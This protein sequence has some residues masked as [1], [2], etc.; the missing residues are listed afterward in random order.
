MARAA[1]PARAATR[2]RSAS[3]NVALAQLVRDGNGAQPFPVGHQRRED[4]I[5]APRQ[6]I[7]GQEFQHLGL[8]SEVV[9]LEGAGRGPDIGRQE[10]RPTGMLRP[11]CPSVWRP[12]GMR[13]GQLGV[14]F[15]QEPERSRLALSGGLHLP[16]DGDEQRVEV[17]CGVKRLPQLQEQRQGVGTSAGSDISLLA[18]QDVHKRPDYIERTPP[19]RESRPFHLSSWLSRRGARLRRTAMPR[20]GRGPARDSRQ[21]VGR[22]Q[23]DL[24]VVVLH[25]LDEGRNRGGADADERLSRLLVEM[26][27]V[28]LEA[29]R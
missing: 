5:S 8:A 19:N 10:V 13:A 28:V 12:D 24:R 22:A 27:A 11:T 20:L 26:M 25:R 23:A 7:V 14:G 9:D 1:W 29:A 18:T 17:E 3:E 21:G 15:V 4:E 16:E 6:A 2:A